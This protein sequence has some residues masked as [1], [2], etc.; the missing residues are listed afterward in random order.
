MLNHW[1]GE[2]HRRMTAAN[3]RA[4]PLGRARFRPA[5]DALEERSTPAVLTFQQGAGGY[6][7]AQDTEVCS[8]ATT[9]APHGTLN[10][11]IQVD[12]DR[13]TGTG[14]GHV[15]ALLR[16]DNLFGTGA[17]QIPLGSTINSAVLTIW[18]IEGTQADGTYNFNRMLSDWNQATA[19]W[20]TFG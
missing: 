11:V 5:L 2:L 12:E 18:G 9:P 13:D 4:R 15:R 7:G 1:L 14:T 8:T 17:G 6:T 16:F 3:R 19:V 20:S 10:T